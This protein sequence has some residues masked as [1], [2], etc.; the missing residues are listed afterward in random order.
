MTVPNRRLG[1]TCLVILLL[2]AA[3]C[4]GGSG[5]RGAE[6]TLRIQDV[7]PEACKQCHEEVYT[8]WKDSMH[9][10]SSALKDPIHGAFYK[11]LVGD[12][13]AEGQVH[14]ASKKY[15]VC[16]KCHAPV[17]AMDKKTKL[18]ANQAYANGIGCSTCHSFTH[19]KGSENAKPSVCHGR[20][21][22]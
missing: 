16:L 7:P 12:P 18:D 8:Q 4:A 22:S 1:T 19:Y 20:L 13:K 14:K 2:L 6:E 15:P 21:A 5:G 3:G 11:K 10:K 9:A 17:A